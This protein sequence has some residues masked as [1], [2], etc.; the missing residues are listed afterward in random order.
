MQSSILYISVERGTFKL[1]VSRVETAWNSDRDRIEIAHP[2]RLSFLSISPDRYEISN[3]GSA[4]PILS[5]DPNKDGNHPHLWNSATICVEQLVERF[6]RFACPETKFE[7]IYRFVRNTIFFFF[8]TYL[9]RINL[10]D[11]YF[12]DPIV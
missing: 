2:A 8:F 9:Y 12:R 6:L 5:E 4:D 10:D 1:L 7:I 3:E 11:R